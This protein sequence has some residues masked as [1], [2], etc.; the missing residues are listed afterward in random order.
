MQWINNIQLYNRAIDGDCD[1]GGG[2]DDDGDGWVACGSAAN[3]YRRQPWV[4]ESS[5]RRRRLGRRIRRVSVVSFRLRDYT[6]RQTLSARQS[7][8]TRPR[9]A[10]PGSSSSSNSYVIGDAALTLIRRRR[11]RCSRR[12]RRPVSALGRMPP[13]LLFPSSPKCLC[14]WQR[15]LVTLR[16]QCLLSR[17]LRKVF[18]LRLFIL[19]LPPPRRLCFYPC[20]CLLVC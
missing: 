13:T 4:S 10:R 15:T 3:E 20:L 6:R 18:Y 8:T 16:W 5:A 14:H 1:G 12:R 17:S 9:R 2:D 11:R 19:L 7:T